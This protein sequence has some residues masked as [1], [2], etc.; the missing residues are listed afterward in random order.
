VKTGGQIEQMETLMGMNA[1]S[2]IKNFDR[3]HLLLADNL[4]EADHHNQTPDLETCLRLVKDL[5]GA[6]SIHI[7]LDGLD[8]FAE[9][10]DSAVLIE[11]I[12]PLMKKVDT[13]ARQNI[14]LKFFLPMN[15][16]A[17]ADDRKPRAL[18]T[19]ILSWD[20]DL[21]AALIRRR[22]YIASNGN[23]GSLD[24]ISAPGLNDVELKI[25]HGLKEEEKLPRQMIL[26]TRDTLLEALKTPQGL[27]Q[28]RQFRKNAANEPD[29]AS[30]AAQTITAGESSHARS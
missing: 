28:A 8:G 11:W 10:M 20:D 3:A 27:I 15:S 30:Q 16:S 13:W 14:Y 12:S 1:L 24:A 26:R 6:R 29:T 7:L 21:L 25:A 22:I 5:L 23:L 2:G 19:E 4:L 9:T 17:L 18:R